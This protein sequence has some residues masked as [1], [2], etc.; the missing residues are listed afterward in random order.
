MALTA[1]IHGF[2]FTFRQL[3]TLRSLSMQHRKRVWSGRTQ[4][5]SKISHRGWTVRVQ[6]DSRLFFSCLFSR[7]AFS[8]RFRGSVPA[9]E[10]EMDT[11]G[12]FTAAS[13]GDLQRYFPLSRLSSR[14]YP[15]P[16]TCNGRSGISPTD[17]C[18]TIGTCGSAERL[19]SGALPS[20]RLHPSHHQFLRECRRNAE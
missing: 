1:R 5:C 18:A 9:E 10:R 3:K 16:R 12:G 17:G 8:E 13:F 14:V 7:F 19:L 20:G 15:H 4:G 2:R 6:T 11:L